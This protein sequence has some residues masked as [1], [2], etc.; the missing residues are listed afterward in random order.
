[1]EKLLIEKTTSLLKKPQKIVIVAHQNPDGDAIGSSLGLYLFLKSNPTHKVS[2][3]MPNDFPDFLKWMPAVENILIF[4]KNKSEASELIHEATLIF[5]LDFNSFSRT[6]EMQNIL[7]T[8]RADFIMIDHHQSPDDYALIAFSDTQMSSTSEMVYHFIC[9]VD[10]NFKITKEIATNLYTGIMTDTGSFRYPSTTAVTHRVL[11]D[12]IDSGAPNSYIHEKVFDI[13]TPERMKLLG[14]A[15]NNLRIL[16]HYKTAYI[17]LSQEELDAHNFKKGDTEGFV[18]YALTVKDIVFAAMFIE[19][20]QEKIIKI[21]FRSKGNF[22]VNEFSQNH[23]HGGGHIN[24][25]GGRSYDS[26][27]ETVTHFLQLLSR[28]KTALNES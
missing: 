22:F 12:L 25:A 15:L 21:S 27:D 28:Y 6:K 23:F 19:D 18:N 24:A 3:I 7:E 16:P 9:A 26:L 5:T 20:K 13:N 8:A 10:E 14:V 1:M 2:I 4:E 11:A 17:T